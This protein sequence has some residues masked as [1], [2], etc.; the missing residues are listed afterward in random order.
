VKIFGIEIDWKK[1]GLS[2][3]SNIANAISILRIICS[4][5]VTIMMIC[6]F[7]QFL[8]AG[9]IVWPKNY[10]DFAFDLYVA[11]QISDAIDGILARLLGITSRWGAFLDRV[12]DKVLIVPIFAL[13]LLYYLLLAFKFISLLA[14]PISGLLVGSIYL[15]KKLAEYGLKGFK[16]KAPVNS[17][18]RGKTKI[19]LQ[20]VQSSCWMLGFL[21]PD[22]FLNFYYFKVSVN[23]LTL[24]NLIF[25]L[26][27]LSII[28]SL[29]IGS[30]AGYKSLPE[31]K[32]ILGL[33]NGGN[34]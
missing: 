10:S 4:P 18:W 3:R 19:V 32:K 25:T 6:A 20:C 12:G 13:M 5:I 2:I 7:Y 23:P 17:N 28:V 9:K 14:F 31:Y 11:C 30:I 1:I 8:T 34:I 29:T 16:A 24:H 21:S 15:E 27:L 22:T 26:V 33:N